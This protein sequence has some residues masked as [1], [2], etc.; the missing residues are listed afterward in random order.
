M[1]SCLKDE[2]RRQLMGDCNQMPCHKVFCRGGLKDEVV[3]AL[4]ELL[5][6]YGDVFLCRNICKTIDEASGR[7]L[8]EDG[9]IILDFFFCINGMGPK[10]GPASEIRTCEDDDG[11][12]KPRTKNEEDK[13]V[14]RLE[15]GMESMEWAKRKFKKKGVPLFKNKTGNRFGC[16]KINEM[17]DEFDGAGRL[18]HSICTL[19]SRKEEI[20]EEKRYI[21]IGVLHLLL[22][23]YENSLHLTLGM[24]IIRIYYSISRYDDIEEIYYPILYKVFCNIRSLYSEMLKKTSLSEGIGCEGGKIDMREGRAICLYLPRFTRLD[25][26]MLV[27]NITTTLNSEEVIDSRES[28]RV[29]NLL[30][31]LHMLYLINEECGFLSYKKF[32]LS[33]FCSRMNFREEFKHFRTRSKTPLNF[34][35]IL[36]VHIK[37]ELIKYENND[38]MKTSLQDSFFKSLFEGHVDPYL[39]I[40]VNRE[41][42]YRDSIEIFKK[43]NVLDAKKQLRTTFKNEE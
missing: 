11:A 33:A 24:M 38:K 29:D 16:L 6:R 15:G 13:G 37:A 36:P 30:G 31:M 35:F 21:L 8:G 3:E 22:K 9:D 25:L 40:T 4:S 2:Y 28:K 27:D 43:M 14:L 23:K 34:P 19:I 7:S 39:F 5:S 17:K 41:T 10:R 18:D 26:S 42:V 1:N 32:Y 12:R 20:S